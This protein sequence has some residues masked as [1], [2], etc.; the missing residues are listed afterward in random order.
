M[1]RRRRITR[2]VFDELLGDKDKGDE[3]ADL[4][5]I[6]E[7]P[8]P[9]GCVPSG[10]PAID[11]AIGLPGYPK[12]RITILHGPEGS[13]KTTEMLLSAAAT[14]A[15]GGVVIFVDPEHKLTLTY[16]DGLGVDTQAMILF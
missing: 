3:Y 6:V 1:E 5:R 9:T 10:V 8:R 14:Q 7:D 4:M 12:G 2:V 13:G 15:E 11:A 16:A